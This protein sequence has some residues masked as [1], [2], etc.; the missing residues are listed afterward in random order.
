MSRG[1]LKLGAERET[2]QFPKAYISSKLIL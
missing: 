1:R 2:I